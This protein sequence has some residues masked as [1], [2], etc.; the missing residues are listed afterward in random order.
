MSRH[1][2]FLSSFALGLVAVTI[3]HVWAMGELL[4][5]ELG[6]VAFFLSYLV[7]MARFARSMGPDM[8]RRRAASGDEGVALILLLAMTAVAVSLAAIVLLL[9]GPGGGSALER[10]VAPGSVPLG[11][12]TLHTLLA[13]HYAHLYYRPDEDGEGGLSFPGGQDPA[14]WDFLYFAFTIGMTAQVSD[15][16]AT[17]GS[18]RRVI[19]F[20]GIGSFFYNTVILA[21]AV[22]AA[23]T[24]GGTGSGG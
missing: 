20:H 18:M 23:L 19:L 10:S 14:A 7:Q 2:R 12:A 22:N 1:R 4:R 9:N 17:T 6:A 13:F 8:L 3:S 16:V 24:A 11:W 21:L 15:V 5:I